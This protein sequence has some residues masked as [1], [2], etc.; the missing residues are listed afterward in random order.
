[1]E[2]FC[3][4]QDLLLRR[5]AAPTHYFPATRCPR[6]RQDSTPPK[7]AYPPQQTC[8]EQTTLICC[9][10]LFPTPPG[11]NGKNFNLLNC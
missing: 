10:I 3:D 7:T 5:L 2:G 9:V 11:L 6:Y 1:M 8:L 4:P